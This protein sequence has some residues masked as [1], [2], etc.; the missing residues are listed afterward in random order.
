[1]LSELLLPDPSCV[2][3][4][5]WDVQDGGLIL[6]ASTTKPEG[7]CPYS[8]TTSGEVHSYY[9]RKPADVP[10]AGYRMRIELCVRRF[11]CRNSACTFT[12]F[13]ER[14]PSVVAPYARRTVRLSQ[15]QS[16]V[17]FVVGG[18]EGSRLLKLLRMPTSPDTLL[19]LVRRMPEPARSSPRVVGIDDW[20]FRRGMTYGTI[21]VDLE[22]QEPIDLL[23]ECNAESIA[24]WLLDHPTVEIISRDRGNEIIKGSTLGAP[25]AVQVADRWHLLKNLREAVEGFLRPKRACLQADVEDPLQREESNEVIKTDKLEE[26]KPPQLTVAEQDRLARRQLRQDRYDLVKRLYEEGASQREISRQL[27]ISTNTVAKYVRAETFPVYPGGRRNQSLLDPYMAYLHEQWQ[28]G[29]RNAS[30]LWREIRSQGFTGS[31]GLVAVW[32]A[33]ERHAISGQRNRK[34]QAP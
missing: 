21:L 23:P 4:D 16:Y 31:R 19:R 6:R 26:K 13:T 25:S 28:A 29:R 5:S 9:T 24:C 20:S 15:D 27:G 3:L 22:K 2:R 11:Y 34:A 8:D 18:E 7:Q 10:C 1:M 33:R 32:A 12:T 17:A 30:Q 14:I